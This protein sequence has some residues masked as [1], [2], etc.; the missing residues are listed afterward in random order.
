MISQATSQVIAMMKM[1]SQLMKIFLSTSMT[2]CN[3][4][5]IS[6]IVYTALIIVNKLNVSWSNGLKWCFNPD[7]K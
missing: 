2:L 4:F 6:T 5:S 1:A 3:N 7:K